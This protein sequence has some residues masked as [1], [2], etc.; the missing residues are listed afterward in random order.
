MGTMGEAIPL[1]VQNQGA[2]APKVVKQIGTSRSSDPIM[3]RPMRRPRREASSP[4]ERDQP[5][6]RK[7]KQEQLD[8][9]HPN[10][11]RH[12]VF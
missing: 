1:S 12:L 11:R 7:K 6:T 4:R 3:R 10:Q 2:R 8:F 9:K 5:P